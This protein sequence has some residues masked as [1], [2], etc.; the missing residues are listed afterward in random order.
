MS[1]QP[2]CGARGRRLLGPVMLRTCPFAS[3]LGQVRARRGSRGLLSAFWER[4][5]P[6][7]PACGLRH[8]SKGGPAR[9]IFTNTDLRPSRGAKSHGAG[10]RKLPQRQPHQESSR[11]GGEIKVGVPREEPVTQGMTI[12]TRRALGGRRPAQCP[13]FPFGANGASI[14]QGIK[15]RLPF[16]CNKTKTSRTTGWRSSWSPRRRHHQC[17]WQPKTNFS[18]DNL[19]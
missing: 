7:L 2:P 12:K 1:N 14:G 11:G 4:G 9:P 5:S 3:L 10:D 17:L 16:Q 15:Q 6:D 8:G 19:Y 18:Q 13:Y